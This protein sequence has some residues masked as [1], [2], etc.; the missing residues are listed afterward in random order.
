MPRYLEYNEPVFC[1]Y[2][3]F[4][5]RCTVLETN[6]NITEETVEVDFG[7]LFRTIWNKI[8]IILAVTVLCAAIAGNVTY[9]L[10]D[11]TYTATSRIYL[12]PR[13]TESLSQT[14]L[15]VGT[16]MTNDAA[17]LAKSKSVMEPV[18]QKLN[19]DT[20]YEELADIVSVE[21][22]TDTRL[23]D[24]SVR[25]PDPQT[26]AD[27]SN[28]LANSLCEQV[29]TIMKTDKPTI[30]ETA[31]SPDQPSAPSMTKNVILAALAGLLLSV[32]L[33]IINFIRDDTIKSQEDVQKYLQLNTLA[34]IPLEY[35]D[36]GK[37]RFRK[38][39]K[40]NG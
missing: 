35:S 9:F 10:I 26:A 18:I 36:E 40:K 29:A 8:W 30:A 17:K 23:I 7:E 4:L 24:I 16:Q 39:A 5:R 14:E 13:E 15:M 31:S 25:D 27:I 34:A 2:F 3:P 11:P 33:V 19:L 32:A 28:A 37:S 12:L 6:K 22:P 21:N 1:Q 38:R 20:T